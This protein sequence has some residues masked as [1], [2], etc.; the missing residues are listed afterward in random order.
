MLVGE[1]PKSCAI[2]TATAPGCRGDNFARNTS[3]CSLTGHY[4]VARNIA[5]CDGSPTNVRPMS[6]STTTSSSTLAWPRCTSSSISRATLSRKSSSSSTWASD[7]TL[8]IASRRCSGKAEAEEALAFLRA[9]GDV[10]E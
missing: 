1:T 4:Y 2:S 3:P 10:S 7:P 8:W 9:R 5:G 6:V